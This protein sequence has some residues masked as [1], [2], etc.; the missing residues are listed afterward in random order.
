MKIERNRSWRI[1]FLIYCVSFWP[2]FTV[3]L[4]V[5]I[6]IV[7]FL[8]CFIVL[9]WPDISLG[10]FSLSLVTYFLSLPH[11][12]LWSS[13]SCCSATSQPHAK[14]YGWQTLLL[15]KVWQIVWKSKTSRHTL[16]HTWLGAERAFCVCWLRKGIYMLHIN[17]W[18]NCT[19]LRTKIESAYRWDC[20]DQSL[21]HVLKGGV[22]LGKTFLYLGFDIHVYQG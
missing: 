4:T 16:H 2:E 1:H 12:G 15:S 20:Y 8:Y 6:I 7:L 18:L 3:S 19:L 14:S 9:P 22:L 21:I 13:V 17:Y 11:V 10:H 5:I